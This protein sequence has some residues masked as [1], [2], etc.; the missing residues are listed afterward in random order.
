MMAEPLCRID[1]QKAVCSLIL[2]EELLEIYTDE[3]QK[4]KSENIVVLHIVL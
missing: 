1:V 3:L 4:K 2:C